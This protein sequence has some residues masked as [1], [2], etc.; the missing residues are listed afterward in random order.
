MN[1]DTKTAGKCPFHQEGGNTNAASSNAAWWPNALNLDILAQHDTKTNPLDPDFDYKAAFNS[2]DLEAVKQDLRELINS[3]QDWWP[4]DYGSYIGMFV[5]TA[6]HLAGS[7]R[8]QD[9]RGGANT[10]NQRFAPLNSWP[11]NVNTDKGR[12]LL[13][14]I[15]RKY[16]NK[17]SWGDL[18]ILAGT[19]AYEEAGLKTFGFGGGRQD[20]WHPEKDV[21]WGS[22]KKWLDATKNRYENDQDRKS[23]DNSLAAVQMGLIYV[24]PEGVDGV[25]D[26]LRT[27]QDMRVTFDRMGM[28]DEET[29]ALTAGGH[30]I[31]KAHGNG[32]AELLGK[33]VEGADVEFQGLGWHNPEGTGN[34][35]NTM[36]SGLEGAWTTHPTKWD[37]EFFYLLFTYEWEKTLSPAGA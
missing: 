1:N 31:G 37:N 16:G 29:V 15:K 22:E 36:V 30:T 19:V 9:G 8:K 4:S 3:S 24:N 34:G 10:G 5:R 28:N 14:P 11:D 13:W 6:W 21:N 20:I 25:Q 2:L 12:R 7:Y 17:I 32:K 35:A 18:I 33:D 26:P 23:L 27:A